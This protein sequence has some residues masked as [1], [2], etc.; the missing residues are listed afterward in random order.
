M[1]AFSTSS[2]DVRALAFSVSNIALAI[3]VNNIMPAFSTS[4][5]GVRSLAFSVN[6][7][8]FAFPTRGS[9][10]VRLQQT[11]RKGKM[12]RVPH[13]CLHVTISL[14]GIP[15]GPTILVV[16]VLLKT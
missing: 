5:F 3:S 9:F 7:I 6:N 4:S 14:N 8:M 15:I 12:I 2:F 16:F 10:G 13:F 11:H 1:V